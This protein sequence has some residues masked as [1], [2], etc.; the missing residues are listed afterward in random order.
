MFTVGN[1]VKIPAMIKTVSDYMQTDMNT[2]TMLK[3]LNSVK[4]FGK[5]GIRTGTLYGDTLEEGDVSYWNVDE[6]S[7]KR[8]LDELKISVN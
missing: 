7:V 2:L 1:V 6:A 8:T 4:I 5:D 3:A